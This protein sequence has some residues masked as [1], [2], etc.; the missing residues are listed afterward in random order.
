MLKMGLASANGRVRAA[1]A[2]VSGRATGP[3]R[4][5]PCGRTIVSPPPARVR[6]VGSAEPVVAIAAEQ[7]ALLKDGNI[8][9][10]PPV[11]FPCR[12]CRPRFARTASGHSLRGRV[13]T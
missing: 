3:G 2:S 4:G 5:R 1:A 6:T 8:D 10:E 11:A 12:A 7:R 9:A 13:R